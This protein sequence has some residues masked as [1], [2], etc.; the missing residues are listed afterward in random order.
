MAIY[1]QLSN[2]GLKSGSLI[3]MRL[4]ATFP[5]FRHGAVFLLFLITALWPTGA[6]AQNIRIKLVNGQNGRPL[7]HACLNVGV[8]HLNLGH[9]LAIPTNEDGVAQF[10]FTQVDSEVN[11]R[12]RWTGCGDFGVINPVVKYSEAVGINAGYVLCEIRKPDYSW[13]AIRTFSTAQVL[14]QGIVTANTCGKHTAVP[15]L[16]EVIIFVRP[17]TWWEKFKN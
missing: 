11:T 17:L 1:R 7:P 16:G 4:G 12:N 10:R 2:E 8:D 15:E 9:M 6:R 5:D 3:A 13:L 14:Q